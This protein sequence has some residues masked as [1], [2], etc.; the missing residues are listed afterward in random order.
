MR[1]TGILA[2]YHPV[3]ILRVSDIGRL[4]NSISIEQWSS[5]YR[6]KCRNICR[7]R[8]ISPIKTRS[9]VGPTHR[10]QREIDK[11]RILFYSEHQAKQ[12]NLFSSQSCAW[13]VFQSHRTCP[14]AAFLFFTKSYLQH[15]LFFSFF[16]CNGPILQSILSFRKVILPFSRFSW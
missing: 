14:T 1:R 9:N 7:Q 10:H 13:R 2:I 16:A 6:G 15:G 3:E 12:L 5:I 11:N 8:T 4:H